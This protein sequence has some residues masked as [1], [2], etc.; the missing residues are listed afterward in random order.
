MWK[1]LQ[2]E[3][4][5]DYYRELW[6][7]LEE[8][9]R[10]HTVYPPREDLFHAL[11]TTSFENTKVVILGQDPYHGP[12]Q[13][14]GLSFSVRPGIK[15]P[16]S[17]KNIFKELHSDLGCPVPEHGCLEPWAEEGVL[18][19]N[20]VLTVRRGEAG[21][22][23]GA[24]WEKFT[25]RIIMKL[26]EREKPVVFILWGK[27][28]REKKA[29]LTNG[30]HTVIESPHPSP[31]SARRGFFGSAPFSKANNALTN[32]DITPVNWE[33]PVSSE[34]L[35]VEKGADRTNET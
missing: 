30:R 11:E 14:H 3:R 20:T 10:S 15:T 18:L 4:T 5:E 17:L 26:N 29:L 25:D 32:A 6:S 24:G 21:S 33:L 16:P 34:H 1:E 19:L 9:Y 12:G 23:R 31:F 22:H 28:A 13:A 8:E 7:F 35:N 2:D 27:H